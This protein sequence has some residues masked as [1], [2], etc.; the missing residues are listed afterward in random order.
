MKIKKAVAVIS[1]I[2]VI[3]VSILLSDS[4]AG[5]F[6]SA[7]SDIIRKTA[8]IS[9]GVPLA[10]STYPVPQNAS[11]AYSTPEPEPP[12]SHP[13]PIVTSTATTT[14]STSAAAPTESQ[15]EP[16]RQDSAIIISQ[17]ISEF[18][19]GLDYTAAG[20]NSGAITRRTYGDYSTGE[21]LTLASGA[22]VRNC[23][24]D[25]NQ[26]LLAASAELPELDIEL[27]S[28]EPQVLIIHTHTTESYEPYQRDYFDSEFPF[29]TRDSRHNM[30]AVGEILAQT[31]AENG[32]SVLHD[33]TIHDYPAYTGAYDRSEETIRAI[34]DEYPSIKVVI[35]LHRDAISD[36]DGSRIAPVAEINGKNAAQFM[37]IAGCD[38]GR[39]NMPN[40]IENF[41]LAALI[42]NSAEL[43]YPTLARAVLFDYRN[44]NQHITTGSLLI[45][46]GSHANSLD[47]ALYTG[48]L[49]GEI[50]ANALSVLA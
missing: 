25:T 34:L 4:T 31:L 17:N 43:M 40:Y 16:Q 12:E 18:D 46:V 13:E 20:N 50:M 32:I 29:R 49:L 37:I 42:Q 33:G 28:S 41:K 19:D 36:S 30:V 3:P 7:S 8:Y 21:Y 35:D 47:E 48:E 6:L 27:D 9:A 22:Q 45:E 10:E 2:S 1:A 38:D 23:T 24:A 11:S 26:S 44:Y 14:A 5:E 39:F 15:Q